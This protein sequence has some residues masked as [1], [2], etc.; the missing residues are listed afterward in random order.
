MSPA[1]AT[2]AT[3]PWRSG[4]PTD[5]V[6][7]VGPFQL[8]GTRSDDPNDIVPH[9]H[10]RDLR[11]LQVF[12]AW[13]NHTRMDALHTIDIVVQPPGATS[14]HPPLPVRLHGD[15]GQRHYRPEGGVGGPGSDLRTGHG[16][17]QHRRP[18]RL[19]AGVDAREVPGSAGGRWLRVQDVRAGQ[20]DHLY[21]VAP[22]ANRLPDDAFWAARQVAAFTDED[23][24]AIV[25]V[26]QYSDPKAERWI[27]DCLIERRDRIGRT[28]FA[29]VLPLD[30]IAVRGAE[31]TFVDLAVQHQYATPRRYRADWLTY[32]NKAGKPSAV[33]GSTSQGQPIPT[34]AANAPVGSYVMARITAE[35]VAPDMAVSL[36]PAP[37][38]G[39]TSRRRHRS[40][41]A[42]PFAGRSARRR[43]AGPK[44]VRGARRRPAADLRQLRSRDER[45]ARRK[46]VPRASVSARSACPSRRRSTRSRTRCCARR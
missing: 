5:G 17:A 14:A 37:R 26:A 43:A 16:A 28:Y 36:Y 18:R 2:A 39:W 27:A 8:F 33:L 25:K 11:G 42:R 31:L 4:C 1:G 7:L 22:F 44:P 29:K 41:M 21:D 12:S 45:Q 38:A 10:R 23:I 6:S 24:R 32:D 20:V 13:L 15:A 19:H 40:R 30:D 9:E 34:E 35:G 46:P 3:A